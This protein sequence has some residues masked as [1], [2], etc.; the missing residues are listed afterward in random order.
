MWCCDGTGAAQPAGAEG[1]DDPAQLQTVPLGE[2]SASR[3]DTRRTARSIYASVGAALRSAAAF[4]AR[5]FVACF[6]G[7]VQ[8]GGDLEAR[9]ALLEGG[10]LGPDQRHLL[11]VVPDAMLA[12]RGDP[13]DIRYALYPRHDQAACRGRAGRRRIHRRAAAEL[14]LQLRQGGPVSVREPIG[15]G[16]RRATLH[17]APLPRRC[18]LAG[19]WRAGVEA[20]RGLSGN[21]MHSLT[22]Q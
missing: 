17:A 2:L 19:I 1:V 21:T 14:L 13:V 20:A 10:D 3:S 15:L 16:R 8:S 22:V 18:L 6:W 12:V 11:A 4:A 7:D 5:A 9:A